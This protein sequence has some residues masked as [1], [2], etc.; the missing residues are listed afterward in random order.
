MVLL[1]IMDGNLH[2]PIGYVKGGFQEIVRILI[3]MRNNLSTHSTFQTAS[4]ILARN[5][6][7]N[8]ST[9][10]LEHSVVDA[11]YRGSTQE[12]DEP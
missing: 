3:E 1:R 12:P 10:S 5:P 2:F 7:S 4:N 9:C 8:F 11:S 6:T